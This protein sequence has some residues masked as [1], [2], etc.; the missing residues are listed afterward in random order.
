[1]NKDEVF[2]KATPTDVSIYYEDGKPYIKYVGVAETNYGIKY[3]IEIPKMG[4]DINN[5]TL[6][7]E[8]DGRGSYKQ[9]LYIVNECYFSMTPLERTYTKEELKKELGYKL[10]IID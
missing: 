3:R 6:E 7:S 1:M 9:F 8:L 5:L 4:L 10:N 2:K